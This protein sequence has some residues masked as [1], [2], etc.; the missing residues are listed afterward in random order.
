MPFLSEPFRMLGMVPTCLTLPSCRHGAGSVVLPHLICSLTHIPRF[1]TDRP[2]QHLE[3]G[4]CWLA[5]GQAGAVDEV[6]PTLELEWAWAARTHRVTE[7]GESLQSQ[8][9]SRVPTLSLKADL[10]LF[11]L[12]TVLMG[13]KPAVPSALTAN[14]HGSTQFLTPHVEILKALTL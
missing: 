14:F 3:Q 7:S 11:T 4:C 1:P 2:C 9:C 12:L 13:S 8:S 6:S 10:S 5:S